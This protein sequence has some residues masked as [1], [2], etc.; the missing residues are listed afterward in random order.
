MNWSSFFQTVWPLFEKGIPKACEQFADTPLFS[1]PN[2]MNWSSFSPTVWPLFGKG[3]PKASEQFADTPLFSLPTPSG[4]H[5]HTFQ[6]EKVSCLVL[7]F[8]DCLASVSN[9]HCKEDSSY[10]FTEIKLRVL[11]PSFHIHTSASNL[12][13][14]RIGLPILLQQNRQTDRGTRTL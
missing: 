13:S 6:L 12:F 11:I 2:T 5:C 7:I 1:I 10:L 3:T 9:L 4:K 8:P 14:P